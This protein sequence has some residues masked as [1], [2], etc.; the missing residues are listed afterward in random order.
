MPT[1]KSRH[2]QTIITVVVTAA[3]TTGVVSAVPAISAA[4]DAQN[5]HK[6]DGKH[7][8]GCAASPT[9]RKGKLVATCGNNGRLPNN[10]ITQA[11]DAAKLGG[12]GPSEFARTDSV[13]TTPLVEM[14]TSGGPATTTFLT[15]GPISYSGVCTDE[16]AGN[17]EILINMASTENGAAYADHDSYKLLSSTPQQILILGGFGAIR[18]EPFRVQMADGSF[19][20][21]SILYSVYL[22]GDCA[23]S[24][25]VEKHSAPS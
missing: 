14:D 25:L 11:P 8:V 5:A 22:L 9:Q 20:T 15:V 4:F 6:V 16:G 10:I 17:Y 18:H 3:V 12:L 23:V 13:H 2:L 7:A 19:Q 24:I 1:V 21:G